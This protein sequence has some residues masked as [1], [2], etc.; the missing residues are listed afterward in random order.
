MMGG[1]IWVESIPGLG[2]KFSFTATFIKAEDQSSVKKNKFVA[3]R[4]LRVLAVD[5]SDKV[6]QILRNY[7]ESFSLDVT[8]AKNRLEALSEIHTANQCGRPILLA[9]IKYNLGQSDGLALANEIHDLAELSIK[10]KTLL[11]TDFGQN[12]IPSILDNKVL[13]GVLE[14][15]LQKNIL[16]NAVAKIIGRDFLSTGKYLAAGIQFNAG[17]V[18]Q[19]RG[20]H[21][22]LVEDNEINQQ[23]AKEML[24]SFGVSVTLAENGEEAIACLQ[25]ES[26]DGVLM[27]MQM[28]VM[29]GVTATLEIRKNPKWA[30]LPILA[31]TANVYVSQQN[32]LLAAGMNDHIG[33]PIDPDQLLATLAKWVR[34]GK[35]AVIEAITP[36]PASSAP[37]PHPDLPGVK[38]A[39]SIRRI[40]GNVALYYALIEKFRTNQKDVVPNI[41]TA[42]TSGDLKTSE[43]LAHTLRG[44]SGSLGAVTLQTLAEQLEKSIHKNE[45]NDLES[46]L[47]QIEKEVDILFTNINQSLA[48]RSS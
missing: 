15:P 45:L 9:I 43:R 11:V 17:L 42:L 12:E 44:I 23:I 37:L 33:K 39:E 10:P 1:K 13:D 24:A 16:F 47:N 20:A 19:I 30:T 2:S 21:V 28:P 36:T 25:K 48:A 14:K 26:Y 22:L 32:E 41:R 31:L 5:D 34:P 27:D 46:L 35:A 6:L 38:V 8:V 7:L 4:G 3:L 40:G 18:S 29:D